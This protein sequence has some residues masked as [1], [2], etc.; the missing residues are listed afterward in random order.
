MAVASS[1]SL[2]SSVEKLKSLHVLSNAVKINLPE[3]WFLETAVASPSLN[4]SASVE[5]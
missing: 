3:L 2:T 4:S 5:S 1:S